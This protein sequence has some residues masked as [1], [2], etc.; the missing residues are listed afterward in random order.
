[1]AAEVAGVDYEYVETSPMTG[2]TK[3]PEFLALNPT[4]T[5]PTIKDGQYFTTLCLI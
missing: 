5:I 2:A 1:M 3:T 4:H